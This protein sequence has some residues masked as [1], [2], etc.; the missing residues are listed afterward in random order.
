MVKNLSINERKLREIY[1]RGIATGEIYG[2][3]TGLPEEDMIWLKNYSEEA[4]R[5]VAPNKTLFQFLYDNNKD[6]LDDIA[7]IYYNREI[8]YRELFE[9]ID[10]YAQALLTNGI[11]RR[12]VIGIT[13]PTTP[14]AIY[15]FYAISKIGAISNLID[16]R[17]NIEEI[18]YCLEANDT[19]LLFAY[20]KVALVYGSEILSTSVQKIISVPATASLNK[21]IRFISSPKMYLDE[22]S[23]KRNPNSNYQSINEFIAQRDPNIKVPEINISDDE[24]SFIEYTSGTTN[25][26]K[27]VELPAASA[28]YRVFQ[29]MNNGMKYKRGEKYLD[30]IPIFVAFGAI[31]GVHL[32]LSLGL[33]DV[34]VPAFNYKKVYTLMKKVKPEHLTLTPASYIELVHDHRFP[35]LDLSNTKT[36]G[37]GGDGMNAATEAILNE[38]IIRQ[39]SEHLINNGYGGSEIG[40]P[41]CTQKDGIH[42]DG[43]VGIPLP[44][45]NIIIFDHKTGQKL[46]YNQIGEVCM[47]VDFPMIQ[48]RNMPEKTKETLIKLADGRI[49]VKLGDAGYIDEDGFIF[50][51]G[52]YGSEI[53]SQNGQEIWPVDIENAIIKTN[54]VKIC[55][56]TKSNDSN[57]IVCHVVLEKGIT[58][59]EFERVFALIILPKFNLPANYS[60]NYLDEMQLTGSGKIDRKT[61][62]QLAENENLVLRKK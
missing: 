6:N 56:V 28:N 5:S 2:P 51:K 23:A 53:I 31:V 3:L 32:P 4:I 43:S 55:A 46:A 40:A 26:S 59:E 19:K 48:Y 22:L 24:L 57:N 1:L 16:L 35:K 61:L 37:C 7:I 52:R 42:K 47:I 11:K 12:D 21:I 29:Y 58:S 27:I 8:T 30:I 13:M 50:I 20:D 60:I 17:K 25:R 38:K 34:L 15:A 33:K 49:G 54:L 62:C 44:G 41:F 18:K 39:K 36:W 10:M 14:E 9:N 45:N